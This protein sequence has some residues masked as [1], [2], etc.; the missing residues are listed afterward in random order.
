MYELRIDLYN[1]LDPYDNQVDLHWELV[2]DL[3]I[4]DEIVEF[5]AES[6]DD[7]KIGRVF[8]ETH[9]LNDL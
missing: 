4:N 7:G 6:D 5:V 9:L 3:Y 1:G 2:Y 8:S